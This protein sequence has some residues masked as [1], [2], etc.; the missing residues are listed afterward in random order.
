MKYFGPPGDYDSQKCHAPELTEAEERAAWA[1]EDRMDQAFDRLGGFQAGGAYAYANFRE[2]E[3]IPG[4]SCCDVELV[5]ELTI[6]CDSLEGIDR[7]LLSQVLSELAH[8]LGGG[9]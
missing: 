6:T 1:A 3:V 2:I 5:L 4:R 7:T 9:A 8:R